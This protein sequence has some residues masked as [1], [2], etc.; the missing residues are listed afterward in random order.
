MTQMQVAIEADVSLQEYQRFEYG[1][2]DFAKCQIS[3]GL[4]ICLTLELDPFEVVFEDGCNA[5]LK[6]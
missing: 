5:A 6:K 3:K 1:D 2:R 4:R